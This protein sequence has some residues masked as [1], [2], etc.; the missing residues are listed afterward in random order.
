MGINY[1]PEPTGI[2]PYTS[3]LAELLAGDGHE[4]T[5][6]TGY[7]H[8][9]EWKLAKGYSGW[10][11]SELINGVQVKRLRHFIPKTVSHAQRMHLEL[12]FG[13]RLLFAKW[14]HPDAVLI[15]SPALFATALAIIRARFGLAKPSTGI[16]VQ[17]IYSRGL[18][19][20]GAAGSISGMLMKKIE[21]FVLRSAT[22]VTVIH[23]RFGEYIASELGV[24]R[25]HISTIRNWTHLAP[26]GPVDRNA[27]RRRLGWADDDVIVLHAG[28][29]GVKQGLGNVVKAA[30]LAESQGSRVRFVLLGDGN[31]RAAVQQQAA[32]IK[33]IQFIDP[34]PDDWFQEALQSADIL[35][36]NEL[37]GLREMAVPSKLTSYFATGLPVIAATE[38]DSTTAGEIAASGAGIRVDPS[39]PK[40]LLR[41]AERL[42]DDPVH[43][44]RLGAAGRDYAEN[45]LSQHAAIVEYSAWLTKLAASKRSSTLRTSRQSHSHNV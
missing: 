19:E 4:V 33:R 13:I 17:D 24:P 41:A 18:E 8:Y 35:L 31:Q 11:R 32:G 16:W 37:S 21:G 27:S 38:V 39:A 43:S 20:T 36:V 42:A 22:K 5:V 45:R 25:S 44:A 12:S 34:L 29:I 40:D 2:A 28:N 26:E 6:L 1:A 15:V 7:P 23:N 10:S 30:R 14:H 3:R 9:P